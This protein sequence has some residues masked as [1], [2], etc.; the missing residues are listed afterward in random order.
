[1]DV[2][3]AA[4]EQQALGAHAYHRGQVVARAGSKVSGCQ[5]K[6]AFGPAATDEIAPAVQAPVHYGIMLLAK[7]AGGGWPL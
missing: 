1:M 2:A 6:D 7:D 3:A 5:V 4:V